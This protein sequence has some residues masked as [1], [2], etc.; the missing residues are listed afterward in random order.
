[1]EQRRKKRTRTS[2]AYRAGCC[3]VPSVS[4]QR[5]LGPQAE[6]PLRG[7]LARSLSL[8]VMGALS[9]FSGSSLGISQGRE[10][11]S[12]ASGSPSAA[13]WRRHP[14]PPSS[15]AIHSRMWRVRT[16][17][18]GYLLWRRCDLQKAMPLCHGAEGT[19]CCTDALSLPCPLSDVLFTSSGG[20]RANQQGFCLP[21]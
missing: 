12:T 5:F 19:R 9:I 13:P 18:Q 2:I 3:A 10:T 17:G 11:A 8:S 21:R 15:L 4:C 16:I 7:S 6:S 14:Q 1:M 20:H